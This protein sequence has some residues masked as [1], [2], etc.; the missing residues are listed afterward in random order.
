MSEEKGVTHGSPRAWGTRRLGHLLIGPE[1]VRRDPEQRFPDLNLEIAAGHE[2]PQRLGSRCF[3]NE[4]LAGDRFGGRSIAGDRR[5][6]PA[7]P[8]LREFGIPSAKIQCVNNGISLTAFDRPP[9]SELRKMLSRES[10][11]PIVLTVSSLERR[12]GQ[13][14]LIEAAARVPEAMFVLVGDGPDRAILE[15]QARAVR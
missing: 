3:A 4:E 5:V 1:Y 7:R 13:Q 12:K 11:R 14:Y 10:G 2:Q 6:G 8:Q 9:H 15:E